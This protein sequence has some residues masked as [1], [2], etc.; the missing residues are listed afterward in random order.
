MSV[1]RIDDVQIASPCSVAWD[2]MDGDDKVRHCYQCKLNVYNIA[3]M[4]HREAVELLGLRDDICIRLFR[5][6]DGTVITRDCPIGLKVMKRYARMGFLIIAGMFTGFSIFCTLYR[7]QNYV[8]EMAG[9]KDLP[10]YLSPLKVTVVYV[11]EDISQGSVI[12]PDQVKLVEVSESI[13]P[14]EAANTLSQAVGR[15]ARYGIPEGTIIFLPQVKE[16]KRAE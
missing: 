3:A 2:D 7:E 9:K 6:K 4:E 1:L 12:T 14:P 13:V 5:R 8:E 16:Y 10:V 11:M 15:V